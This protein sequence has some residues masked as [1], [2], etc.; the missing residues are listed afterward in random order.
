MKI[1]VGALDRHAAHGD[2]L[3]AMLAALGEHDAERAARHLRV[4]EEQLVE[5]AHPVEQQAVRIG[6]LDLDVLLH[7]RRDAMVFARG[8]GR[9]RH[10][11]GG[12][13]IHGAT[14]VRGVQGFN[15]NPWD[16]HRGSGG[17][18]AVPAGDESARVPACDANLLRCVAATLDIAG[19]AAYSRAPDGIPMRRAMPGLCGEPP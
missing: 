15:R 12:R 18:Y 6:G 14:L 13:R 9:R 19:A 3:A 7:Q 4:T 1:L 2:V 10:G 11:G 16:A 8:G 5:V 17:A